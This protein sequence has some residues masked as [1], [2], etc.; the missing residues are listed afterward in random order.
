MFAKKV[1]LVWANC[2]AYNKGSALEGV[3]KDLS[4]TFSRLYQEWV[5]APGRP[6]DPD[7]LDGDGEGDGDGGEGGD[8]DDDGEEEREAEMEEG[9][10]KEEEEGGGDLVRLS[11]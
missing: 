2:V 7:L 9:R 5:V 1:Q 11:C 8:G 6:E 4:K 3:A 10:E